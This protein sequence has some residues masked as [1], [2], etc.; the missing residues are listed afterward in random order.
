VNI[1]WV[2]R[3]LYTVFFRMLANFEL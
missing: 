3:E 2:N 1:L